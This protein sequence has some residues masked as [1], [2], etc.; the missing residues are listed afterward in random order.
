[1]VTPIHLVKKQKQEVA[2]SD[3]SAVDGSSN[4]DAQEQQQLTS[5]QTSTSTTSARENTIFGG[6][7]SP[8]ATST[9]QPQTQPNTISKNMATAPADPED[10][11][12]VLFPVKLY[13]I[14]SSG[15]L[16]PSIISWAPH[17][18]AWKVRTIES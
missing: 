18:R 2:D 6:E 8:S 13:N 3:A 5:A 14:L 7:K 10:S 16:D 11:Y 17:G 1:M 15:E 4:L 9:T 12:R